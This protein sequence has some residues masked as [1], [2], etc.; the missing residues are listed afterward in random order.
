MGP[1]Y[2]FGFAKGIFRRRSCQ[3]MKGHGTVLRVSLLENEK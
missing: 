2:M 1:V 3:H